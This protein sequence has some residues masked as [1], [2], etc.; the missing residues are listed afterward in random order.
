MIT[1]AQSSHDTYIADL[2][3]YTIAIVYK[4][5]YGYWYYIDTSLATLTD[6]LWLVLL[7]A[8]SNLLPALGEEGADLAVVK[9]CNCNSG[10]DWESIGLTA[11][12]HAVINTIYEYTD[13]T[14]VDLLMY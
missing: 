14:L 5:T 13:L 2:S 8:V 6:L 12:L 3:Q 10:R 9:A 11:G 7:R 4:I 1:K